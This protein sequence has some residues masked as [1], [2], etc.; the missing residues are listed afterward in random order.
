MSLSDLH[1]E[2]V[3]D[4][5]SYQVGQRD[6]LAGLSSGVEMGE[7]SF[8]QELLDD[9]A[10]ALKADREKAFES[11][12]LFERELGFEARQEAYRRG[13]ADR[14]AAVVRLLEGEIASH[15]NRRLDASADYL[16]D[17]ARRVR[18]EK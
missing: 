1:A 6:A 8:S 15:Q 7:V 3:T 14:V 13:D 11:G 17:L 18:G 12:R 9:L 16:I 5:Y 4:L 10:R 2:G